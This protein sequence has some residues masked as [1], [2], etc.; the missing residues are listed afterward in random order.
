MKYGMIQ[1]KQSETSAVRAVFIIDPQGVIR[2]IF[3]YPQ[4][5][6]RNF[7]ELKRVIQA[8]QATDEYGVATPAN[9]Q[10]GDP[11]IIPPVKTIS[12]ARTNLQQG[13]TDDREVKDWFMVTKKLQ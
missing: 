12:E 1:P 8:L 2:S 13:S 5:T 11:A 4:S 7:A 9:W 3:Y 10:P 6:G